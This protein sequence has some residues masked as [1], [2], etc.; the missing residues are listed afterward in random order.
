[1]ICAS[2]SP[3][4]SRSIK[5]HSR[6]SDTRAYAGRAH[7]VSA[8]EGTP[9]R[10]RISIGNACNFGGLAMSDIM[11]SQ[12]I[13]RRKALAL[14]GLSTAVFAASSLVTAP[15]VEAQ[16]VGMER[17]QGRRAGRQAKRDASNARCSELRRCDG[18]AATPPFS[19]KIKSTLCPAPSCSP[20]RARNAGSAKGAHP[21]EM[22][23]SSIRRCAAGLCCA[24]RRT[25][26]ACPGRWVSFDL[27]YVIQ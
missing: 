12:A 7:S 21:F 13:S 9:S 17:R 8:P 5:C 6:H 4:L 19:A 14:L 16:T 27:V 3:E 26:S 15:D 24:N 2:I 18:A 22:P 1:M 11:N 20:A 25:M 10:A 23:R